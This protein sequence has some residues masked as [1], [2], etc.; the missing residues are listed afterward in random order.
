M[1]LAELGRSEAMRTTPLPPNLGVSLAGLLG[2]NK[3]T[4]T[5]SA[6]DPDH[7]RVQWWNLSNLAEMLGSGCTLDT[8]CSL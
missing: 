8:Y 4:Q 3:V 7:V 6:G 1:D 5:V 2:C